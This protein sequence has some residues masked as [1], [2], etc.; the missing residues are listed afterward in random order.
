MGFRPPKIIN[1]YIVKPP[2]KYYKLV[3]S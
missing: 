1:N 2:E 3:V